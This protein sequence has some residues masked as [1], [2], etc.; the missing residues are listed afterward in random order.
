MPGASE[1]VKQNSRLS[2]P[3]ACQRR[4]ICFADHP[5][6]GQ[7]QEINACSKQNITLSAFEIARHRVWNHDTHRSEKRSVAV[8]KFRLQ[9]FRSR[10]VV[11]AAFSAEM[12]DIILVRRPVWRVVR[13]SFGFFSRVEISTKRPRL[14]PARFV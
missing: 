1:S 11:Q 2:L 14:P 9:P 13:E 5:A 7:N 8:R 12:R 4:A 6:I 3:S 10:Q